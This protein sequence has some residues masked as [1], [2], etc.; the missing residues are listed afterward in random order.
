[1]CSPPGSVDLELQLLWDPYILTVWFPAL[2]MHTQK[3]DCAITQFERR[4]FPQPLP[5]LLL[6]DATARIADADTDDSSRKRVISLVQLVSQT[7]P[8]KQLH[9]STSCLVQVSLLV[10]VTRIPASSNV[11]LLDVLSF[12]RVS[13][14]GIPTPLKLY[15]RTC[16]VLGPQDEFPPLE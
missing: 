1:M 4:D 8:G 9:S 12:A 5:S 11:Q 6:S 13:Q 14:D 10:Q 15:P 3:A 2:H 7:I 16:V